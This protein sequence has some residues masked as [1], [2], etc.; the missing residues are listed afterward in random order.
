M[1]G[2]LPMKAKTAHIRWMI[3]R[4]MPE[5]MAIEDQSCVYPWI[6]EDFL[7]VLRQRNCIGMVIEIG[8]KVV[9][10]MIYELHKIKLV[11]LNFAVH[12]NHRRQGLGTALADK[13][14]DKLSIHRRTAIEFVIRESNSEGQLFFSSC[15]FMATKL[16]RR[17]YEEDTGEDGYLMEF[18]ILGDYPGIKSRRRSVLTVDTSNRVSE[19]F[20]RRK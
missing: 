20:K 19:Y 7:A 5:V 4:D 8:E 18:R 16:M 14:K 11:V 12:A 15:G 6:E 13:L 10:F 3:R 2:E 9:G 17:E 1:A